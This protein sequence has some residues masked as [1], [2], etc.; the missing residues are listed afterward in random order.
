VAPIFIDAGNTDVVG[1]S[2]IGFA[3]NLFRLRGP[4]GGNRI[5]RNFI[6]VDT[7]GLEQPEEFKNQSPK[8]FG[9]SD[10]VRITDSPNNT[11][12]NNVIGLNPDNGILIEGAGSVN[13]VVQSNFIGVTGDG[14]TILRNFDSGV[15]IE[16]G[17]SSNIIGGTG[18][19]DGNVISANIFNGVSISGASTTKN[20]VQG[21]L[22]G[23]DA[24]GVVV[25]GTGFLA[26]GLRGVEIENSPGNRIGGAETGAGNVISGNAGGIYIQGA[27][28][29]G[30]RIQGNIVGPNS[31]GASGGG[32]FGDGIRIEAA[33]GNVIGGT[34]I[35]AGNLISANRANGVLML[36]AGAEDNRIEGN[37]IGSDISGATALGNLGSGVLLGLAAE[38]NS[39]G[40]VAPDSGNIIA[41]NRNNG[42]ELAVNA[43]VGNTILSNSIFANKKLGIDLGANGV[44]ENDS[45]DGD[46][47]P[48]NLQ[49]FPVVTSVANGSVDATGT[50]NSLPNRTMTLQFFSNDTCSATGVSQGQTFLGTIDVTTDNAGDVVFS[51]TFDF[52]FETTQYI[53]M[54]ATD[55]DGNTSEFSRCS[56]PLEPPPPG[57]ISPDIDGSGVVNA[58][59]LI[60][61]IQ[62]QIDLSQDGFFN[63]NDL[64]FFLPFWKTIAPSLGR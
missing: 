18:T 31:S 22:I 40:G 14:S 37:R 12:R 7:N 57:S 30:N 34:D 27:A 5:E 43:G 16:Q 41:F 42:V 48:N 38:Q 2:V 55:A 11:I 24:A 25:E 46:L 23:T 60:A 47:G 44:T 19:N 32:N 63:E 54:T 62:G 15:R 20:K 58:I 45:G 21:N 28:A 9:T 52:E 61:L 3:G 35:S 1:L 13:N 17:A 8:G 51:A 50:L 64:L 56:D 53:T 29:T 59:D 33:A 49:N 39:I 4:N 6:G 26:N 10:G 36:L